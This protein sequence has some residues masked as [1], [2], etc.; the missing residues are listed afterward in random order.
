MR[1]ALVTGA[2]GFVGTYLTR[3]LRNQGWEVTGL[4]LKPAQEVD[5]NL[6]GNLNTIPSSKVNRYSYDVVYH[7][8][9]L[10]HVP[11]ANENPSLAFDAN[12]RGTF[13]LLKILPRGQRFIFISSGDIYGKGHTGPIR[14][15]AP[16]RPTNAYSATKACADMALSSDI[17]RND[18][19]ILRPFNHT[20][21]GQPDLF[22]APAFARQI[23]R[24]EAGL[25]PPVIHVGNLSPSRDFL[26]VR[27]VIRA[28]FLAFERAGRGPYNIGSGKGI[29]IGDLLKMLLGLSRI[30]LSVQAKSARLR[31]EESE[32]R[33]A[34]TSLFRKDTGWTPSIPIRKTLS[35]LLDAERARVARKI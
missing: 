19:V 26:D 25:Q 30:K 1:K 35:D 2:A 5:R 6:I 12:V 24:A 14:E 21:P 3:F 31:K 13:R 22:A 17:H 32:E 10:S 29:E 20:G 23:A 11:T 8:A 9:A 16:L 15:S 4:D 28:Y 18:L 33:I 27:D 34:N 7:L